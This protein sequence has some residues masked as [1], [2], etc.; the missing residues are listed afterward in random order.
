MNEY[1]NQIPGASV[2]RGQ[3]RGTEGQTLAL[4]PDPSD[5]EMTF[6]QTKER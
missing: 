3:L 4:A 2:M 1:L 5:Y 6:P